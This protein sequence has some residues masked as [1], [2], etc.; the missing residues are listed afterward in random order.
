MINLL[1]EGLIS[2]FPLWIPYLL[3]PLGILFAGWYIHYGNE[4]YRDRKIIL[5]TTLFVAFSMLSSF[6]L[7]F[8]STGDGSVEAINHFM[9]IF[10]LLWAVY[11]FYKIRLIIPDQ[12]S[13]ILSLTSGLVIVIVGT[14]L[15]SLRLFLDTLNMVGLVIIIIGT[16]LVLISFL[17]QPTVKET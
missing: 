6:Y 13:K 2:D 14:F 7:E 15:R 17:L 4:M 9:L 16:V 10:P 8:T 5:F 12:K 11:E 1:E 3:A